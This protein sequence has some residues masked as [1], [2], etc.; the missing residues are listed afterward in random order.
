MAKVNPW[1]FAIMGFA[2]G[3]FEFAL[4]EEVERRRLAAEQQKLD[5]LEAIRREQEVRDN[6]E[7]EHRFMLQ[8]ENEQIRD[9][10]NFRQQQEILRQTQGFTGAQAGLN[11]QHDKDLVA[12]RAAAEA[13][14]IE[15]RG[16]IDRSNSAA[17]SDHNSRLRQQEE[18]H[19]ARLNRREHVFSRV[20]DREYGGKGQTGIY[21]SD[22]Q[23]YPVGTPLPPGVTPV[24]GVGGITNLG[25]R[26]N[27]GGYVSPRTG[28]TNRFGTPGPVPAKPAGMPA[29][30]TQQEYMG[31]PSGTTYVAPDG[32]IRV[33]P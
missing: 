22:N 7:W 2:K 9:E 4:S 33:K 5:R 18:E 11:R 6:Q 14:L 10:V 32:S 16:G 12:T 1:Q 31:L 20:F 24:A 30:K 15:M 28:A 8:S 26:G 23:F 13:G 29:P 27:A 25:A 17:L 3:A 21:G 19:Q